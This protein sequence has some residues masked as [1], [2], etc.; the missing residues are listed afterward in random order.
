LHLQTAFQSLGYKAGDF[1]V[2]EDAAS[3]Y[4]QHPHA[5]LPCFEDQEEIAKV[6]AEK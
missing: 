1:P 3:R 5:S 2:S 6:L 4:L